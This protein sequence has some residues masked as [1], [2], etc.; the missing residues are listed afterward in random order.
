MVAPIVPAAVQAMKAVSSLTAN[1]QWHPR[2]RPYQID[3]NQAID[4]GIAARKR[5]MLLAMATGTGKTFTMVN[6][7]YRHK[8]GGDTRMVQGLE[9]HLFRLQRFADSR[10]KSGDAKGG[11]SKSA[12]GGKGASDGKGGDAKGA[13]GGKA[14]EEKAAD[15]AARAAKA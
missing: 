13:T 2:L 8:A 1:T 15:A 9:M 14:G 4:H 6:Q 11:E 7:V 12:D 10:S 5:L 3:A